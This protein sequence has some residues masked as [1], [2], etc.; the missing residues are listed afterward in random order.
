MTARAQATATSSGR[1]AYSVDQRAANRST[2]VAH[3]LAVVRR[4]I[5][6]SGWN[7]EAVALDMGIDKSYLSR[8][9]S[10]EKP[11]TFAHLLAMPDDAEAAFY[12]LRLRELNRPAIAISPI[13]PEAAI[14]CFVRGLVGVLSARLPLDVPLRMAKV[15]Q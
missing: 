5:E 14:E 11:F 10:G 15:G 7:C 12:L 3:G 13:D 2:E 1:Q 4:A 9:L 8:L 6:E